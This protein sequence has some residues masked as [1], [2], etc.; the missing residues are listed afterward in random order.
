MGILLELLCQL[1]H[2]L[3]CLKKALSLGQ[4]A[5]LFLRGALRNFFD[6]VDLILSFGYR[7]HLDACVI[8]VVDAAE[9]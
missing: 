5:Y 9:V 1:I 6:L 8:I 7:A 4:I 3:S 2:L